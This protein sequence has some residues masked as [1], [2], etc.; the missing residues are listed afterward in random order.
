MGGRCAYVCTDVS[1]GVCVIV[2]VSMC[3]VCVC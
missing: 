3:G 2:H 1:V